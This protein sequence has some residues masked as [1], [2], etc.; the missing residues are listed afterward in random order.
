MVRQIYRSGSL[1]Q[2]SKSTFGMIAFVALAAGWVLLLAP[3]R[4]AQ[5]DEGDDNT[6]DVGYPTTP[7]F[8]SHYEAALQEIPEE[9]LSWITLRSV[10]GTD[11]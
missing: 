5:E 2:Y 11:L 7:D 1:L 6:Y 10:V 9:D 4:F 8:R 3:A